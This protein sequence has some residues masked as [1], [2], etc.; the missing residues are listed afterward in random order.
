M[1]IT[2]GVITIGIIIAARKKPRHRKSRLSSS[3]KMVPSVSPQA[4]ELRAYVTVTRTAD[5]NSAL[6]RTSA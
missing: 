5:Q 3:A 2:D 6:C 1:P 4:I